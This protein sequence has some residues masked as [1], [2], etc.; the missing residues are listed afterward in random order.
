MKNAVIEQSEIDPYHFW[1][2]SRHIML[3]IPYFSY[4]SCIAGFIE[5][6]WKNK[7]CK[8][9]ASSTIADECRG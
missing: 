2:I 1:N 7:I 3:I 5:I 9:C 4:S 8:I 6:T